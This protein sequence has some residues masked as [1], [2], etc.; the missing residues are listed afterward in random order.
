MHFMLSAKAP[1]IQKLQQSVPMT[2]ISPK[3]QCNFAK[4]EPGHGKFSFRH[5]WSQY[6][7]LGTLC[8][9][10]AS[11]ME[12]LAS[13][14]ITLTKSQVVKILP[15]RD[16]NITEQRYRPT[17]F[18]CSQYPEA[19][20]ELCL[21]VRTACG[22]MSLH[23]A[24]ALRELSSAIRT[25]TIPSPTNSHMSVAIKAAKG[26]RNELSEDADLIQVMHV[27]VIAS[28]LSE[29]VTQIKKI[30]ESVDNLARLACFKHPLNVLQNQR[31][32]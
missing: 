10:C 1:I 32:N 18:S 15:F 27:A 20:P 13:Y 4:W 26:L 25:M 19:N 29:L 9:Q 5:P 6:Q 14:V 31:S 7:K 8:R 11:S 2:I 23:S 28:L 22:E 21:K 12:A 24:K 16:Q 30:T 3:L 17:T